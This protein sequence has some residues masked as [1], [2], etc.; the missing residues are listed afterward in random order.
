MESTFNVGFMFEDLLTN[1]VLIFFMALLLASVILLAG[2][3]PKQENQEK[4]LPYSCGE[5]VPAEKVP[6]SIHM[7]E[8]AA[9][10]LVFDVVAILLIF[11]FGSTSVLLP[12]IYISLA[13]LALY[14]LPVFRRKG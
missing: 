6:I 9:V 8:F 5:K 13:A 14:S 3:S 4:S 12:V 1:P 7:F 11:S 2:R 10:F